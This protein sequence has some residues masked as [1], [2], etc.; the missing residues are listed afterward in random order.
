MNSPYLIDANGESTTDVKVEIKGENGKYTLIL[1]PNKSWINDK[2]RAYP[3]TLDPVVS[4]STDIRD[5]EDNSVHSRWDVANTNYYNTNPL[6]IGKAEKD[7]NDISRAFI[8]FKL[9]SEITSAEMVLKAQLNLALWSNSDGRS[10]IN[11]HK[12]L[13][14]WDTRNITWNNQPGYNSRIEDYAMV[15]GSGGSWYSWDITSIAKEWFTTGNNYG[16]L[17]KTEGD[18]GY[19]QEFISSDVT[20][21]NVVAGR[22]LVQFQFINACGLESYWTYTTQDIGRAGTGYVNNYNGNLTLIH[23]DLSMSGNRLPISINHVFNNYERTKNIGY[24]SGFRLN[25]AQTIE[26][27]QYGSDWYYEHVD[28]DGT[29]QRYKDDGG[30]TLKN[31]VQEE[32]TLTKNSDGTFTIKDTEDSKMNFK[33][34][35]LVSVEDSNGNK[36]TI[37]YC[38][39]KVSKVTDGSGRVVTL[40][41]NGQGL[42]GE[43]VYPDGRKNTYEYSGNSLTKITYPDGKSSSYEYEGDNRIMHATDYTGNRIR[44]VYYNTSTYRMGIAIANNVSGEENSRVNF[45]YGN[46]STKITDNTGKYS[47]YQFDNTGKTISIRDDEGNA[48]YYKYGASSNK[49]KI[50]EESKMQKSVINLL[51]NPGAEIEQCWEFTKDGGSGSGEYTTSEKYDGSKSLKITKTDAVSRQYVQDLPVGMEKGKA[52]TFS[53]YVKTDNIVATGNKGAGLAIYYLN[54]NGNYEEV[55][56]DFITGTMDWQRIQVTFTIPADAKSNHLIVRPLVQEATGT[57]YFDNLQLEEGE[58]ANRFNYIAN[59][60]L[61]GVNA[62]CSG[63]TPDF[64]QGDNLEVGRDGLIECSDEDHPEGLSKSIMQVYT[65]ADQIKRFRYGTGIKGKKGDSIVFSSWLKAATVPHGFVNISAVFISPSGNTWNSLKINNDC[66][67]WQYVSDVFIAPNDYTD[68]HIYAEV[69]N[70]VNPIYFD[71]IQL[72]KEEFGD[73]YTYDDKGNVVSVKDVSKEENTFKYDGNNNLIKTTT[74]QGTSFNYKYDDKHKLV[75]SN[76]LKIRYIRDTLG[77]NTVNTDNTW[78]EIKALDEKGNN[79]AKGK[80]VTSNEKDAVGSRANVVDG[81][82]GGSCYQTDSTNSTT[83]SWVQIDLGKR[84]S[85]EEV[86]VWH[87]YDGRIYNNTKTEVSE[88]GETWYTIFDCEKDGKYS[89]TKEGRTYKVADAVPSETIDTSSFKVRYIRDTLGEN[90]VNKDNTWME[91]KALDKNGNNVAEGKIV[92]SNE[93]DAVGSKANVVDGYIGG[94]C[95]Q[96]DSTNSTTIS[97]VQIDLG[98]KYELEEVKVWH[99]Y[100]GRIYNNTKTEVSED[101]KTWY[102]LFDCEKDGKYSETKEGRTYK[103]ADAVPSQNSKSEDLQVRYIKDTLGG[104][105][106]NKD[107]TWMEIKALDKDGKNIA[108]GK[109]VISSD[110]DAVGSRSNVVDGNSEGQCYQTESTSVSWVQIDLGKKYDIEEIQVWHYHD[111]RIYDNTKTEVSE[112][113]EVWYTIFDCETSGKY[114]ETAEGRTYKVSDAVL[115]DNTSENDIYSIKYDKYGNPIK[116]SIG[117]GEKSISSSS[118][119]TA[120]GNYMSSMTD[121]FGNTVRYDYDENRD[122]LNSVTDAKGSTTNYEYDSLNRVTSVSKQVGSETISNSYTYSNDR[123]ESISHNGFSY[124]FGYDKWGNNTDVS[125]GNQKLITNVFEDKTGKLLSSTYGNGQKITPVYDK[126]DNLIGRAYS[127]DNLGT[128]TYSGNVEGVGNKTAVGNNSVLGTIGES[129]RLESLNINMSGM[130][131]GMKIKYQACIE[132][133]G[134]QDWVYGGQEAGAAGKNLKMEAVRIKLE[135]APE[136]YIVQYQVNMEDKGWV[137]ISQDGEVA[138]LEGKGKRIEAIK[139]DLVKVRSKSIYDNN[140]NVGEYRDYVSGLN[141]KYR[142]D[143][144]N[145]LRK[146]EESTGAF[147]VINYDNKNNVSSTVETRNGVSYDTTYGYDEDNYIN[148]ITYNRNNKEYSQKLAYDGLNRVTTKTNIMES[149]TSSTVGTVTYQTK[150]DGQGWQGKKTNGTIAGS[151]GKNISLEGIKISIS[152][153]PSGTKVKYQAHCADIGWQDW[154]YGGALAGTDGTGKRLEAIKIQLE[155]APSGYSIEYKAYVK[156]KGWQEWVQNGEVAGTT[157]ESLAMEA[158]KIRV[159]KSGVSSSK[160]FTTK[161]TYEKGKAEGSGSVVY[162]SKGVNDSWQENK[163]EGAL[164]GTVGKSKALEGIKVSLKDMPSGSRVKYRIY[165]KDGAWKNW[166]YDGAL[167]GSEGTG[168]RLEAVQIELEGAPEGYSIEYRAHVAD[169]GWLSW[170]GEGDTAGTTGQGKAMEALE[171]RLVKTGSSESTRIASMDNNGKKISYTY[172]ANGN[173]ETITENG[174]TIKYYY[175]ELNEVVR[176]DNQTLNKTI[177]YSYDQGGNI[178]NKVEYPYTTGNLG[179]ASKTVGYTYGDSNWK[180][181]LTAFNGKEITY[182]EI[183]NPLTYDGYKFTWEMGRQLKSISGNGKEISYKYNDS[184]I[185]TEK[186]VNGVTT[187][188]YLSG[189]AVTLL[190][191]MEQ[192]RYTIHMLVPSI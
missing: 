130:P 98:K 141:Y 121:S 172:D 82:T 6:T 27:K 39:N 88:D 21:P 162:Q 15:N 134:W 128:I 79:I 16:L 1:E 133:Q 185:R 2:N 178:L 108:Q 139:I 166:V 80:K 191:I 111:G 187:K 160:N 23:D 179:T 104:N 9:P 176:E 5:I 177:T 117:M 151:Y 145:R 155:G 132:G 94:Q 83:I 3:V 7:G 122:V 106:V 150:S 174:K 116:T 100:D 149:D 153:L 182:D 64:W 17:L 165:D 158:I 20:D 34:G 24:G 190:V 66:D 46:N 63:L 146:V 142:Y 159:V 57:A 53:A 48:K 109:D 29:K 184:G 69:S 163:T 51:G 135:D 101:G 28:E 102:T 85:I 61:N 30:T 167:A 112:D 8:K 11:V 93:N 10:Q 173:I 31:E 124:R 70:Q 50:T 95:Y 131:S 99:Y 120:S 37:D 13:N 169:K 137:P 72:F 74:P 43:I 58:V 127:G 65:N 110:K 42:L 32:L 35:K 26:R 138:G 19:Y 91:I 105:T 25:L 123:L 67:D 126:N 186:T 113:G 89:E 189:D 97:W 147:T 56:S 52:Y 86:K 157:G 73:S 152:D 119:Y 87:Y 129:K 180:D 41:Y 47:C 18:G 77:G 103:V 118:S 143:L 181:K 115:S 114:V 140:G 14:N 183:G 168:N 188:Y 76:D 75:Q 40:K 171:V 81:D 68:I 44:Y 38:D 12:V 54:K 22:P 59:S 154:V 49:G 71:G 90:T 164:S 45:Q 125:V 60:G 62:S 107:N 78:M 84:Y 161:Y 55:T 156:D 36:M 144:S 192:I 136:G 92:T 170:V 148:N 96:T 33:D 175:N 4:T